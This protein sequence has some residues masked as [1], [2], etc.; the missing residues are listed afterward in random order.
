MFKALTELFKFSKFL[1]CSKFNPFY[2]IILEYSYDQND[3]NII[4]LDTQKIYWTC[5]DLFKY[6]NTIWYDSTNMSKPVQILWHD[7]IRF[8]KHVQTCS[9]IMTRFDT[10]LQA[11]PDLFKYYDTIWYD[12]TNMSKLVQILRH[13]LTRFYKHVQTCSNIKT[14]DINLLNMSGLVQC[15]FIC[16]CKHVKTSDA[17]WYDCTNMSSN[18]TTRFDMILQTCPNLN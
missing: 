12:S 13:D 14:Q 18:I 11:S 6:Y 16:F 7:L 9:N 17:N 4:I 8:Y 3:A 2:I 1:K 15:E 5:L 10:I